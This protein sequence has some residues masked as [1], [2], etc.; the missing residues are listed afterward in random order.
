[1]AN[2]P[3]PNWLG[4]LRWRGYPRLE[5]TRDA[6]SSAPPPGPDELPP[7]ARRAAPTSDPRLSQLAQE[8]EALR[9]RLDALDRAASDFERRLA[10]AGA[11]YEAAVLEAESKL[12]DAALERERTGGELEA[13]RAENARLD[14]R[15]ASREAELRLERERRADAEKALLEARRKLDERTNEAELLRAAASEQ[16]GAISELR[17]QAAAQNDRLLQAKALTDE[18]VRLLRQEMREFLAKF[19]RIQESYG[20]K[21]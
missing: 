10:D 2:P 20:E 15:D 1:M 17:R 7:R 9:A 4:D 11:S 6:A 12:R 8:N 16:A 13:A 19:H 14:A 21:S 18:D 5:P 3:D